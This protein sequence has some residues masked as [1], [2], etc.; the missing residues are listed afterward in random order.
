MD[1]LDDFEFI[2]EL[3]LSG[4]MRSIEGLLPSAQGCGANDKQLVI[5]LG[6]ANEAAL[7]ESLTVLPAKHLLEVSAHL[8]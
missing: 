3:A 4:G 8:H 5:A 6:N 7:V 1:H 2:S